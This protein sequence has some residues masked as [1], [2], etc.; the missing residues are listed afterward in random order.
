M[1]RK[2]RNGSAGEIA[3]ELAAKK[4]SVH[5]LRARSAAPQLQLD[6]QPVGRGVVLGCAQFGPPR[7]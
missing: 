5:A 7:V 4:P 6:Q 1:G 3:T 2:S